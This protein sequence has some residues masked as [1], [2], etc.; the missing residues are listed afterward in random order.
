MAKV[1]LSPTAIVREAKRIKTTPSVLSVRSLKFKGKPDCERLVRFIKSSGEELS[2]VSIPTKR[3]AKKLLG[4]GIGG[5]VA[6]IDALG[7]TLA[8]L[9]PVERTLY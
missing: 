7:T 1:K 3:D 9:N 6:G 8:T 2:K 5:G 4:G